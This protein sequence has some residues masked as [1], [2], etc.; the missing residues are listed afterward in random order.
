MIVVLVQRSSRCA[1]K[2]QPLAPCVGIRGD[3]GDVELD[4]D[5]W[6]VGIY[7]LIWS[8][9]LEGCNSSFYISIDI[10]IDI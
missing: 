5:R 2:K 3:Q 1:S 6:T 8:I 10:N 7:P 4:A 9:V